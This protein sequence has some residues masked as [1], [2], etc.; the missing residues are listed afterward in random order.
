MTYTMFSSFI[1]LEIYIVCKKPN[2]TPLVTDV[3]ILEYA[4]VVDYRQ[5]NLPV[6]DPTIVIVRRKSSLYTIIH[7]ST[8]YNAHAHSHM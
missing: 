2:Y 8:L 4:T 5:S 6:K 1:S 7:L 3:N